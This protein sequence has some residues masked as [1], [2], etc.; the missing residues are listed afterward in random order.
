MMHF[1][2]RML[3]VLAATI[4]VFGCAQTSEES[5]TTDTNPPATTGGEPAATSN[6]AV[7][8]W[9]EIRQGEADLRAAIEAGQ[10]DQVHGKAV[11]LQ[12]RLKGVVDLATG[13]PAGQHGQLQQ[14]L[15]TAG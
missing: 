5:A 13:L 2:G 1:N 3:T 7:T 9:Q 15:E 4:F 11:A 14:R 8:G 6:T 12:A 10:L